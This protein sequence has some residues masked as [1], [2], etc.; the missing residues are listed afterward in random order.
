MHEWTGRL[1]GDVVSTAEDLEQEFDARLAESSGLAFRAH[2][3]HDERA[4]APRWAVD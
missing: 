1:A 2:I 4:R 3:S